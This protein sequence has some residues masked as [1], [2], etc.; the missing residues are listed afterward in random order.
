[1]AYAASVP[2]WIITLPDHLKTKEM[3]DEAVYIEPYSLAFFHNCFK[4]QE[5]CNKAVRR[6]PYT[7]DYVPYHF[8][9]QEMEDDEDSYKCVTCAIL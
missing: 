8:R 6:K 9:L 2:C 5:M 1:M 3:S 4:T 7:L